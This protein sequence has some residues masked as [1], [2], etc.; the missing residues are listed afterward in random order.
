MHLDVAA[1]ARM[2]SQQG[3]EA[4]PGQFILAPVGTI[5][6]P[7]IPIERFGSKPV[8]HQSGSTTALLE[9]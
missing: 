6:Y 7:P 5:N 8:Q 1:P 3:Y 9:N 4:R 2:Y